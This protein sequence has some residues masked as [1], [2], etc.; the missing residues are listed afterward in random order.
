MT[1]TDE[2]R[3]QQFLDGLERERQQYEANKPTATLPCPPW[4]VLSSGHEYEGTL[5]EDRETYVRDHVSTTEA[6]V[7]VAQEERNRHGVVTVAEP[8]VRSLEI[9]FHPG[10]DSTRARQAARELLEAAADLDKIN[11]IASPVDGIPGDH[12]AIA[13]AFRI[14]YLA[15]C[16]DA[17]LLCTECGQFGQPVRQREVTDE[18]GADTRTV[19]ECVDAAGCFGRLREQSDGQR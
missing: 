17:G 16:E 13:G 5:R 2:Q 12:R 8:V 3:R 19:W 10:V 1:S 18:D 6:D 4:C 7:W 15:S 9:E 14:G 11:G